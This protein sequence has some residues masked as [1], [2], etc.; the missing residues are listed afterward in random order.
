MLAL[1]LGWWTLF[2]CY[3][4]GLDAGL[5]VMVGYT[6]GYVLYLIFWPGP[7]DKGPWGGV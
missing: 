6:V 2:A 1:V 4:G 7:F 5:G 3:V